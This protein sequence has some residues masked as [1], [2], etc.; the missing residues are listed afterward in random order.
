MSPRS[1][2]RSDIEI[3]SRRLTPYICVVTIGQM[4]AIAG[5]NGWGG[6]KLTRL[7]QLAGELVPVNIRRHPVLRAYA[8]FDVALS[9]AGKHMGQNDLWIASAAAVS[10]AVVLTT[11]RDF[12]V[13]HPTHV[14]REW[15][16]PESLR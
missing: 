9:H 11:D 4:L 8:E 16:D 7:E 14:Q 6:A 10:K 12:D 2:W 1:G 15:I 5:R 13:L 3:R